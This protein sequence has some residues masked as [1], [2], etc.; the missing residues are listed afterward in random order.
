MKEQKT[1]AMR[2]LEQKKIPYRALEY[3]HGEA[4][5]DGETVAELT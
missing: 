1:N 4:P 3:P 5:V 2:I